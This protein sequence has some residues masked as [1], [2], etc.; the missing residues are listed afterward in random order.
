MSDPPDYDQDEESATNH[1]APH[2]PI[3]ERVGDVVSGTVVDGAAG[4]RNAKLVRRPNAKKRLPLGQVESKHLRETR[5]RR[6]DHMNK[7]LADDLGRGMTIKVG[8]PTIWIP[9]GKLIGQNKK[10]SR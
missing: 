7:E 4:P 10:R 6:T 9:G 2:K 1:R 5:M 3:L 8:S